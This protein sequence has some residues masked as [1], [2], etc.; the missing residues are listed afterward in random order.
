MKLRVTII[1]E[2]DRHIS[3]ESKEKIEEAAKKGWNILLNTL[4]MLSSDDS[5]AHVES[6]ELLEE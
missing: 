3:N 1:S 4:S 6:C 5:N 2:N